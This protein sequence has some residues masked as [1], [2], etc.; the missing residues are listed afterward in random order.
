MSDIL[1]ASVLVRGVGVVLVSGRA[2]WALLKLVAA[3][4]SG[5]SY[6]DHPAPRWS[7]YVH[8]LRKLGIIIDTVR[9]AHDGPFPG[10][11]ARYILRI[12]IRIL[13]VR[14]VGS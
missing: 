13:E 6:I 5:C 10:R 7:G 8:V 9:E 11:H 3:G 4:R 12:H 1:T 2:A 14:G